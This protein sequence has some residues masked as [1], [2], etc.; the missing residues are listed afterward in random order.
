MTITN[1]EDQVMDL[2]SLPTTNLETDIKLEGTYLIHNSRPTMELHSSTHEVIEVIPPETTHSTLVVDNR[3]I[4]IRVSSLDG[5]MT[6]ITGLATPEPRQ[7]EPGRTLEPIHVL[8]L[9]RDEIHRKIDSISPRGLV[10]LTIRYSDDPTVKNLA[11][12]SPMKSVSHEPMTNLALMQYDLQLRTI[13]S[14]RYPTSA[15]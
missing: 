12:L 1:A 5:M 15:R 2:V 13:Q 11:D 8:L 6:M 7:K 14:M 4:D 3:L 10:N 9:V